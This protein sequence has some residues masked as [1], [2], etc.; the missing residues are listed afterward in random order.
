MF[1]LAAAL[2]ELLGEHDRIGSG[3][4]AGLLTPL[5]AP[6]AARRLRDEGLPV[7]EEYVELVGWHDAMPG[8]PYVFGDTTL[9]T[10]ERNVDFTLSMREGSRIW[11]QEIG[12]GV[13]ADFDWPREWLVVGGGERHLCVLDSSTRPATVLHVSRHGEDSIVTVAPDLVSYV[14]QTVGLFRGGAFTLNRATGR[15][16][17]A[18]AVVAGGAMA[19]AT[20]P[21]R[22]LLAGDLL[23]SVEIRVDHWE[24]NTGTAVD[25][26]IH[27][28][29]PQRALRLKP[30]TAI[31][32]WPARAPLA[33]LEVLPLVS[34]Q[35]G[36]PAELVCIL[37]DA[38]GVPIADRQVDARLW[39]AVDAVLDARTDAH[40][41]A[42]LTYEP[43]S[44]GRFVAR[45]VTGVDR[46][47]IYGSSLAELGQALRRPARVPPSLSVS[48]VRADGTG[49]PLV[50]VRAGQLPVEWS[51]RY[52]LAPGQWIETASTF[53]AVGPAIA[54]I[55]QREV[56]PGTCY[57]EVVDAGKE[58]VQ[59]GLEPFEADGGRVA[60]LLARV[61]PPLEAAG[62]SWDELVMVIDQAGG[63]LLGPTEDPTDWRE[64]AP[65]Q[66]LLLGYGSLPAA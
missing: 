23:R 45:C 64:V 56:W 11:A 65:E 17:P 37:T 40:G 9:G 8:A 25:A 21:P 6:S 34:G 53:S 15:V 59:R 5:S 54:E 51:V 2:Q 41:M 18:E 48:V 12:P 66:V 35:V 22:W 43:R 49:R 57:V 24:T 33:F 39:G 14:E 52:R 38:A 13:P 20:R 50:E 26:S 47:P 46:T 62:R 28:L 1:T 32:A 27:E 7:I 30:S 10:F 29:R 36:G 61:E 42:T 60:A 4:R 58:P 3:V 55:D 44:V 31:Y 63:F 19:S 16:G